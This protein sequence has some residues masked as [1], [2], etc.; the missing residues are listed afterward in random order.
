[1][2]SVAA[3]MRGYMVD[4][5]DYNYGHWIECGDNQPI[6]CD[7][8]YCCSRCKKGRVLKSNLTNFCPNCGA[9]LRER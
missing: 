9:D 2:M 4:F 3:F 6:S 8:V 1:M 5:E 7:K